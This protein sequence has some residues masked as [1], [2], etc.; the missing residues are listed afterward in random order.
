MKWRQTQTSSIG[1]AGS[2]RVDVC[3]EDGET[4]YRA[5]LDDTL[6]DYAPDPNTARLRMADRLERL[7]QGLRR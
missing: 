4:V 3:T 2:V 5:V 1:G 6:V 7:A